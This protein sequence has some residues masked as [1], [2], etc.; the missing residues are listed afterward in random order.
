[1]D[2][3]KY[4]AFVNVVEQG[5]MTK[6]AKVMGYSQPGI[7]KMID[8]LESELNLTLFDRNGATMKLTDSGKLIYTLCKDLVKREN[9]MIN[10]ANAINGLITGSVKIGALN[11]LLL[12]FMPKVLKMYSNAYPNIQITLEQHSNGSTIEA[13][14]NGTIDIGF[15]SEVNE[16]GLEFI[17]LF[18]DPCRLI[19]GKQHAF[20]SY[21]KIPISAL[22]GCEMIAE[23]AGG[24]EAIKA[25][26]K[27]EKFTP[28]I[29]YYIHADAAAQAMV[30]AGLGAYIIPELQC[31][32]L[33]DGIKK[34]EFEEDVY[35]T[36]GC[37]LRS[38]KKASPA[39]KE[40]IRIAKIITEQ[41][42][43]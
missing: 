20:A 4:R 33:P 29:R 40:L 5:N 21:D 11:S 31:N 18:K 1:M 39:I 9:E 32:H 23:P 14:H 19:V 15:T 7:G 17:P 25:V 12:D 3:T 38:S 13:L 10:A 16:K 35:R 24:D 22:N 2:T 8:S 30:A 37:A 34:I 6:A 27:K 26:K 42:N 36:M 41:N 28:I 43:Y